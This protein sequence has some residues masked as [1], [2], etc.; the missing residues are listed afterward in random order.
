MRNGEAAFVL[1]VHGPPRFVASSNVPRLQVSWRF[2]PAR[3]VARVT[4][5]STAGSRVKILSIS[6]VVDARAKVPAKFVGE[7][8][9]LAGQVCAKAVPA[10][11]P[12]KFTTVPPAVRF[13]TAMVAVRVASSKVTVM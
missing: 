3:A 1:G 2:V 6:K 8:H 4:G 7:I 13:V 9:R 10:A 11:P 12:F 5:N